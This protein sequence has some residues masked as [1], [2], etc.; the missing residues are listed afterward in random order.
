MTATGTTRGAG[1]P[2]P[3][4]APTTG[5]G[6]AAPTVTATTTGAATTTGGGRPGPGRGTAG[7]PR[8]RARGM[9]GAGAEPRPAP[10][11]A[12]ARP[13]ATG[14]GI[15]R[16]PVLGP[17][18]TT[19]RPSAAPLWSG[20]GARLLRPAGTMWRPAAVGAAGAGAEV[21]GTAAARRATAQLTVR[22][23]RPSLG[24]ACP[25]ARPRR[26]KRARTVPR[27]RGRPNLPRRPLLLLHPTRS[28][29]SS[30]PATAAEEGEAV[31]GSSAEGARTGTA[32]HGTWTARTLWWSAGGD[33]GL[34]QPPWRGRGKGGRSHFSCA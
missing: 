22:G 33:D 7:G 3:A 17:T 32:T 26:G 23:S 10:A 4:P 27:P 18:L 19:S 24:S 31:A 16:G 1:T 9:A 11:P 13:T 34:P 25:R 21:R 28:W 8:A 20:N 5:A 14:V 12:R 29:R 2:A 6:A 15:G 30:W